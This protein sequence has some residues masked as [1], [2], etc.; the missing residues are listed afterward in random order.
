MSQIVWAQNRDDLVPNLYDLGPLQLL[1]FLIRFPGIGVGK[2]TWV[3][4]ISR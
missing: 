1:A 2:I 3:L 4:V